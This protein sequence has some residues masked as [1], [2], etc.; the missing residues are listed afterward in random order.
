MPPSVASWRS[1]VSLERAILVEQ[2]GQKPQWRN[3]KSK[4]KVRK[5]S[6]FTKTPFFSEFFGEKEE[7]N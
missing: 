4:W 1:L 2:A 3:L 6:E 5:W 7:I